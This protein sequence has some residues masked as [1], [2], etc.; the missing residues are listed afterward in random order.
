MIPSTFDYVRAETVEDAIKLL[1]ESE[2]EGKL[3]AGG[4]SLLPL[5]KFRLTSPGT[6]IDI[7]HI[8]DL[9]GVQLKDER[10]VVGALTTHRDIIK[11]QLVQEHIPVLAQTARQIGDIQVRSR[12]TVGGNIAHADPAADLPGVAL[13]LEAEIE[14]QDEDGK[15]RVS[16]DGFFFGPLLT[17]LPETSVLTAV[18]FL[19]PPM[20]AKSV[21]V[22]YEHPASGYA[23]VGVCAIAG[24]NASGKVDFIRVGINGV[25]DVAYRAS[26]VEEALL[27][28]AVT[29]ENIRKAALLAT[30]DAEMSGDMFASAEY[31]SHLCSIYT[32]RALKQVLL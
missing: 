8:S 4:H 1:V 2:G 21:Y 22:K 31:R 23:V 5:M 29:E 15:Q 27:G 12:G 24:K 28:K 26:A 16:A 6:L 18:S 7:N 25:S 9:Q 20:H 30:K 17:A 14:L 13:A 19:I 10:L 32:E 11:D 3:L